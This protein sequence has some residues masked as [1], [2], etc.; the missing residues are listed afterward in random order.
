MNR[1]ILKNKHVQKSFIK[2]NALA[3]FTLLS[4]SRGPFNHDIFGHLLGRVVV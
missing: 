3:P 2:T 1:T 4:D